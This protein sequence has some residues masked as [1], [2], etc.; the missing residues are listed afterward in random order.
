MGVPCTPSDLVAAAK[1][2]T[3]IPKSARWT[4]RTKILCETAIKADP[5]SPCSP[6]GAPF[7]AQVIPGGSDTTMQVVWKQL[8][9]SGSFITG[10]IVSWGTTAGGP[11]P[12][13][14]GVLPL[15]PRLYVAT[16]LTAGTTYYFTVTAVTAIAGCTSTSAERSGTTSFTGCA[17]ATAWAARVVAN[18]GASPSLATQSAICTFQNGLI[19]DGLDTLMIAWNAIVPDNLIAAITPQL[20]GGGN[21]PWTN[22][23]GPFVAGDLTVNGLIGDGTTKLLKTGIMPIAVYPNENTGGLTVYTVT[24]PNASNTNI[25]VS[26]GGRDMALQVS[27]G[28]TFWDCYDPTVGRISGANP[29]F[30]G[31]LSA[32]RTGAAATAIYQANSVTPHAALVTGANAPT[33][34]LPTSELYA[35]AIDA[36]GV[37]GFWC[38]QRMSFVAIHFGLTQAQSL[39]FFNRIQTLRTALGG[40][41]I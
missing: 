17:F 34:T 31:Y 24:N 35:W 3:C 9:N 11:Y 23:T 36:G 1:C 29:L 38:V 21:D 10:Y 7:I 13:N 27:G 40:G 12:S 33:N 32:N 30:T 26:N 28:S 2:F 8:A 41:F 18:G 19:A 15:V 5:T 25:G 14:S 39:S 16:G 22:N 4:V 37:A 20:L 6:P